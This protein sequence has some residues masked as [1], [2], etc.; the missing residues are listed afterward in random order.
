MN[1]LS[2]A[3]EIARKRENTHGGWKVTL[4]GLIILAITTVIGL[5]LWLFGRLIKILT[6][7]GFRNK[8]LYIPRVKRL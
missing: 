8:D 5:V 3:A 7:G 2:E 1:V 4:F 6:V